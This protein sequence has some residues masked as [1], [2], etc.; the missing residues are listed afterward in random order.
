MYYWFFKTVFFAP[1]VRWL[2]RATIEGEEHLPKSGGA[3]LASNHLSA[4]DTYVLP[5]MISRRLTFPAKAEL[6]KG[7]RGLG[8]K[9]VAVVPHRDRPGST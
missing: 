6:F 5:A 7:D 2:F 1:V 4:G 9:V 3:I 8:S